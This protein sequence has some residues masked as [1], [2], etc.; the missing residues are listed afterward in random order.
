MKRVEDKLQDGNLIVRNELKKSIF[1][2]VA[3]GIIVAIIAAALDIFD[4]SDPTKM[5]WAQF[6]ISW[7]PYFL[8]AMLLNT[9]LYKKGVFEASEY[10]DYINQKNNEEIL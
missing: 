8:A 5:D 6:L 2:W 10:D 9:D 1:D 7:L 3:A 4:I